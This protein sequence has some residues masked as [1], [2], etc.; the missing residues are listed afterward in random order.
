VN[1]LIGR[2]ID[3]HH[4]YWDSLLPY[5]IAA[6]R[7][8][9]HEAT[10]FT[11]NYL[12]LGREVRAPVD[13]IYDANETPAPVSYASYADEMGDRMREAYAL[14][15]ENLKVAAER[16]KRTYDLRVRTRQYKV[17]DWVYYFNPRKLDVCQDKWR[18]KFT[19][20]FP[21]T[22]VIGPV[23]VMLQRSKRAHPFCTHVD[24]LKPYEAD[25]MP[26]SWLERAADDASLNAS[27]ADV[28][29]DGNQ[30][31]RITPVGVAVRTQQGVPDS[32]NPQNSDGAWIPGDCAIAGQLTF[33]LLDRDDLVVPVGN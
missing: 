16:N 31:D 23:N 25:V 26:A 19:G 10:K 17:G 18:R 33:I 9:R 4:F 3:E 28:S 24:K 2:V 21:V 8:S 11:P 1:A 20:P 32:P 14:V 13:L 22:T 15:R 5:V 12:V 30:E 6:Y 29:L 7:A 27:D